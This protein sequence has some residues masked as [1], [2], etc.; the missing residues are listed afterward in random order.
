M[1]PQI[2]MHKLTIIR[3]LQL[4]LLDHPIKKQTQS[5]SRM[6]SDT[7]AI[8]IGAATLLVAALQG[9]VCLLPDGFGVVSW[10]DCV[11]WDAAEGETEYVGWMGLVWSM[12]IDEWGIGK[13]EWE[14]ES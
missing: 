14:R 6:I 7:L 5:V 11:A 13:R 10:Y 12:R 1:T 8:P 3:L 2:P 4:R 9:G